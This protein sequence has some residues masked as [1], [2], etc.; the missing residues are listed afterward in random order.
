MAKSKKIDLKK[1]MLK[2]DNNNVLS[3]EGFEGEEIPFENLTE[4]VKE[5]I[6]LGVPLNVKI[7]KGRNSG[8]AGRKPTYKFICPSCLKEI[9]TKEEHLKAICKDC[10]TEFKLKEE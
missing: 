2:I 8:G 7:G 9:S 10:D 4:E 3:I 5:M 1:V 6:K